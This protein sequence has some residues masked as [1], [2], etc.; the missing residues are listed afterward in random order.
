MC[1]SVLDQLQISFTLQWHAVHFNFFF[2][3]DKTIQLESKYG[4]YQGI[5]QTQKIMSIYFC[6]HFDSSISVC[7]SIC[8]NLSDGSYVLT[9]VP[10][11]SWALIE[12]EKLVKIKSRRFLFSKSCF[13]SSDAPKLRLSG[14]YVTVLDKRYQTKYLNSRYLLP[15]GISLA[16]MI[17]GFIN[18]F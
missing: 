17:F 6:R 10:F 7:F 5:S 16:K 9:F 2:L 14:A 8:H 4:F 12:K 3:P 15:I 1:L 13:F 18:H 11:S